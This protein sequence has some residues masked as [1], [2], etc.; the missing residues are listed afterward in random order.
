MSVNEI[1]KLIEAVDPSDTAKLDEIDARVFCYLEGAQFV[2]MV[3]S[4]HQSYHWLPEFT[5]RSC[6]SGKTYNEAL[7]CKWTRSRD[8]LKAIRPEG[9]SL[10]GGQIGKFA[11]YQASKWTVPPVIFYAAVDLPTEELAELHAI[12]QAIQYER[13]NNKQP[14]TDSP[15]QS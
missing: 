13:S 1:L 3:D 12:L 14:E 11:E 7:Y 6:I 5:K 8:A 15:A 10:H 9:W 4:R 2:E